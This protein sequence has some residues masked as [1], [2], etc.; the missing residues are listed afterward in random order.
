MPA[1]GF[2][3]EERKSD[4]EDFEDD[5]NEQNIMD[6]G[7]LCDAD[8]ENSNKKREDSESLKKRDEL[9]SQNVQ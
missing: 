2:L 8:D 7:I 6:M 1:P 4:L 9:A 5:F 3:D